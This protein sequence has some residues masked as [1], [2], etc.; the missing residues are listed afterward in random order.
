MHS[1]FAQ[2]EVR[3]INHIG[4]GNRWYWHGFPKVTPPYFSKIIA[5]LILI[6]SWFFLIKENVYL[7]RNSYI[8]GLFIRNQLKINSMNAKIKFLRFSFANC[9]I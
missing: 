7:I 6:K 5:L 3:N 2:I 9:V 1:V 8:C 4:R